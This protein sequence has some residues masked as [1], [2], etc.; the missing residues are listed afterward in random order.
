MRRRTQCP[1]A[2]GVAAAAVGAL[3]TPRFHPNKISN[4][5]NAI[6]KRMI[7]KPF[8]IGNEEGKKD[9]RHIIIEIATFTCLERIHFYG[10]TR[11]AVSAAA[12]A[13]RPRAPAHSFCFTFR[14][15]FVPDSQPFH[16]RERVC[17]LRSPKSVEFVAN[18]FRSVSLFTFRSLLFW[19]FARR[20]HSPVRGKTTNVNMR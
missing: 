20:I 14:Q 6:F 8:R 2:S 16:L 19:L 9:R 1:P 3:D 12:A 7:Q 15:L 11:C 5:S 17:A 10:P 18:S 4:S 13:L